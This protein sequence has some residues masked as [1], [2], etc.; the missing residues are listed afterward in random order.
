MH[1]RI[2]NCW[3][4]GLVGSL[5]AASPAVKA[6]E[7]LTLNFNP[8]WKFVQADV[9]G[10][11]QPD[12]D[13]R[14]W[15]T[16]S[17]PH[18]YNDID[19]F[20]DWSLAGHR[21]EQNQWGG[22]T[23]YRKTFTAPESWKGKKIF[24]E[25]EAVRQVAEVYL[26]GKLLG[27]SKTGFT[28]FGFDLTPQLHFGGDNVLAVMCDNRFMKDPDDPKSIDAANQ[29]GIT[30]S[31]RDSGPGGE[32]AN[33]MKKVNAQI[34][35]DIEQL[36][37]DQ[38]P[39]NNPHWHPAHGGI[40]RNVRLVV[41]DPLHVELPL[42]SF[43]QT[44]GPY[45]YASDVSDK[46]AKLSVEVPVEN[47]RTGDEHVE[48]LVDVL[49]RGGQ[50]VATL[51]HDE[52]VASGK[53]ALFKLSTELT[54]PQ[55]WE[56]DY[57]YLYRVVCTLRV[58]G[59]VCDTCEL[60][61]GIRT[62]R[63]DKDHGFFI[64]GQHLKLH[65]WGQKPT[66]EWPGLG[67]A[68]PDWMHFYTLELMKNAG[69]NFVRWGHCAASPACIAAG[70]RLGIIFDQP[71]VDGE[72]DTVGAAWKLRAA[73]FRDVLIYFRNNPSI[74]IWEGGNQKV[75]RDH[76]A[77]LRGYMDQ[78][79]PHGGRVYTHRRADNTTAEFMQIALGTEGG[80]E[81][82]TLPVVEAEYDREES[83]RRVWDDQSPPNFGYPE[84][85]GQTYQLNSEQFAVNQVSQYVGKIGADYHCGG[86]NWIFSDTTSGGRVACEVARAGGEVDGV[87]LPKEAYYVCQAMF[88]DDPQVHIIGHWTYP[89][90]TRKTMYVV[91]NAEEVEFLVNGKSLGRTKP[92]DR[93][94]F[95]FPNVTWESGEIKALAYV[96]N[97]VVATQTKH[98]VG[99]PIALKMTPIT[100]PDGLHAD[101]SDVA[102]IDVEAVDQQ[103]ER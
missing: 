79:D 57:P 7:R 20:D 15:T 84:A 61:F 89:Q 77:E 26:N 16:V 45:I 42:Y 64:N 56:P 96:G 19:T 102:L 81:I 85:K 13:D 51:K 35:E 49:D 97:T 74:L 40:Y 31:K 14:N 101:G 62:V 70:D 44:A 60:P 100:G 69:A 98:T 5:L 37:A 58:G 27:V 34:P 21:G 30:S 52:Q 78:Y 71:G 41:T 63:W 43:L 53:T 76:A 6:G 54:A 39:W 36:Q 55:L 8:D 11:Q 82:Q 3:L 91:S 67:A 48:L 47:G 32:L 72:S 90:G 46:S 22:R 2:T 4:L 25:F 80:R 95:T 83:P 10:A 9:T 66:D 12:F 88:R 92:T 59:Q 93:Y 24:I 99:A 75:T 73:A 17:V 23:W 65:G 38:I 18:T 86:A 50:S 103:G 29:A 68:Q 28:P 87:R 33:L 1:H 94:L